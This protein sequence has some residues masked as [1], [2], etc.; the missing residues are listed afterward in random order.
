MSF[1]GQFNF[2]CSKFPDIPDKCGRGTT[3]RSA[4]AKPYML[5]KQ[6]QNEDAQKQISAIINFIQIT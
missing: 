5:F 6:T 3:T 4:I 2:F 1:G